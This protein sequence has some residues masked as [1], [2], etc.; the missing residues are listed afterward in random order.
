[1][2][3]PGNTTNEDVG[4]PGCGGEMRQQLIK[5][6]VCHSI[7][8]LIATIMDV[9]VTEED[10]KESRTE[11]DSH[12]NMPVVGRHA[13][14]IAKTGRIAD[15]NAF[16]PDYSSMQVPIVDAARQYECPYD[17]KSYILIIR[18]ALH[19]PSMNN[20]L[21][22]PFV[23]REAGVT[24]NDTPKIQCA[25]PT[26]E[27]HSIM[28][29]ET[30]FRIPLA[31]WGVFSYFPTT[32]PTTDLVNNSEEVYSLT[33]DHWN[34]HSD[35]Y[36]YNEETMLDWEGNMIPTKD[37]AAKKI[38]LADVACITTTMDMLSISSI[39]SKMIDEIFDEIDNDGM[40]CGR[41][42]VPREVDQVGSI[43][44][45][46]SPLLN[47]EAL[48]ERLE[49]QMDLGR[50]KMAIGSTNATNN[51][52]LYE[53]PMVEMGDDDN[54][55]D[56]ET[57]MD[58]LYRS[59]QAGATDPDEFMVSATH[60]SRTRGVDA[61]HVSKVWRIDMDSARRTLDAT[62]QH[63][64]RSDNPA[65][66]RNYSTN[67]RMIRYKRVNDY[68]F[69]DTFF[70]T[71]KAGKSTR[72]NTCCQL[73]VTDKGFVYVVPMRSKS[74]VLQAVKQFAKEIGAPDAIISDM[75]GEQ[76]SLVLRKF[77]NE[78]RT[79]LRA[80]EEGT[81]WANKAE[82]YIG[83]IKEAVRK[84]MKESN[85]PLAIWDYCVERRARINNLTVKDTFKLHGSNP[86]TATLGNVGDISNIC[87]YGWYEWCYYREQTEMFPF[88]REVLG[89]VLGPARGAGNE[90]AQWIM[91][92]NGNVVP[93][94]TSRPLKPE[95]IHS[96][97]EAE[98]RKVFD[99]LIERRWGTSIN[100]PNTEKPT[101]EDDDFAEF[102]EHEDEDE[103]PRI[104]P[105]IEDTVDS[106]GRLLNQQPAYDRLLQAEVSLQLDEAMATGVVT[107][108]ATGPDGKTGGKYDDN[109]FL[110]SMIY[111][112]EFPDGQVK[113]Y[114]ANVIAENMLTQVDAEGYST[115][116]LKNIIDFKKE[117]NAVS[118]EDKYVITNT[119]QRRL[120][121]TTTGWKLLIQWSNDSE[122]WIPLKDMKESHPCETA[123]FARARGI[124]DEPAFAWWV[125]YTLRKQEI[126]LA[127][128]KAR[129]RK[130]THKYGIEIPTNIKHA[131]EIAKANNNTFWRDAVAKEMTE[132]G[133]AFEVLE[134]GEK[135]PKGWSKVTGRLVWDV[136]M[137]F[138]RKAR[139]VLDGHLTP[140][141]IGTQG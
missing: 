136:K 97:E 19:V 38:I 119:G 15:V 6:K 51:P 56:E 91:K 92:A 46:I 76:T 115:T 1:M 33:P 17:S 89:R 40:A 50:F 96:P 112:V 12:A 62:T 2:M 107:R 72:N 74:E 122:T 29:P 87:Q 88:N 13:F 103:S 98:K 27:D 57:K 20:N 24:V 66:T 63:S 85:C 26:E 54:P 104:I 69:M 25:S 84:D 106:T 133:I 53:E 95:E 8:S 82:L 118:K 94:R 43:L 125:P 80:L 35:A 130:T 78:I 48:Y 129:I 138:T 67:D 131:F 79:T 39:E 141:P 113:E 73:F 59:V 71:Q 134:H 9:D 47:A 44:A 28:F 86:H 117:E 64:S 14:I 11:L 41:Q 23:M 3:Q 65:Q 60:V 61:E 139:W 101:N 45:E 32:K 137:D 111:E 100:P 77:C 124:A 114:A 7:Y 81:P 110:N 109:P 123:E 140:N 21:I 128:I 37:R 30:G 10:Q 68:F 75:A 93:R 18:N 36:A 102:Y 55:D 31:L 70:A 90:M 58:A 127:K 105:E 22:P 49:Q 108:R 5:I 120:R 16:T 42:R 126:I 52:F 99:G 135:A 83:I 4:D 34:P 121:K 132:V 116:M